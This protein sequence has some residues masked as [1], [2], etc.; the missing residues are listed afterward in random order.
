ME[1]RGLALSECGSMTAPS[2]KGTFA[3]CAFVVV[4]I[5]LFALV[6]FGF[7]YY[8]AYHKLSFQLS[9]V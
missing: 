3:C 7:Y 4:V 2:P 9:N 8:D 6:G 5:V 1:Y